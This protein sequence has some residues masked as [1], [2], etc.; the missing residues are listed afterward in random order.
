MGGK[1]SS[2]SSSSNTTQTTENHNEV[3]AEHDGTAV[4]T[5]ATVTFTDYGVIEGAA[6]VLEAGLSQM[7]GIVQGVTD[8]FKEITLDNNKILKE[9]QESDVKEIGKT[10]LNGMMVFG[11]VLLAFGYLLF[12]RRR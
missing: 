2:N 8:G 10:I 11:L 5:R 9:Q 3:Y 12:K 1:S 6:D 4:G 7:A